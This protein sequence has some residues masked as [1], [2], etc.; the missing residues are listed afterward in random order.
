MKSYADILAKP[1]AAKT[2][3]RLVRYATLETTSD[4][5]VA[6]IPSTETQWKLSRL[7][8]EELKGLGLADI[9]LDEHCYL[10]ARLPASPGLEGKPSI[11]FMAH[12]DTASDVSGKDVKPRVVK[13]YDGKALELSPGF[14]LDP[15]EFPDLPEHAGDSIVVTDGTTLLGADDKAGIAEIMTAVEWLIAHP[16][17]KHGPIEIIFT[18]DEET[19]K[20]MDLFPVKSL[21]SIACYTMDG[22]KGGE[23][24]AECFNAYEIKADFTGKAIHIGSARGKLANAVSMA[25]SF[26]SMLPRSEAPESTDGWYGYFC[27]LEMQ[28][29]IEKAHVD[30]FLRDFSKEGMERRIEAVRAIAKAVEAQHPLGSVTLTVNKQYVNMRE[31]LDARPEVLERAMEAARR[32]GVDPFIKPIRGGTD[33]ARLTELGIPTPNLFTGGYNYHSRFEWASVAEMTQAVETIVELAK[34]WA[35]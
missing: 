31:K 18:P 16:E 28:G 20:G 4:R 34:L 8:V 2:T 29:G 1:A 17:V 9:T 35:Q 11:G 32:A 7:L 21:R 5:H 15:R 33:G 26:I 19:G 3:E 12:V 22:G 27:P 6:E 13:N 23:V 14:T 25:G 30:V 24:E 10:I